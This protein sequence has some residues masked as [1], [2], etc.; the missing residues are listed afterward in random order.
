MKSSPPAPRHAHRLL[1][2]TCGVFLILTIATSVLA[3]D[4]PIGRLIPIGD[5]STEVVAGFVQQALTNAQANHVKILVLPAAIVRDPIAITAADRLAYQI[6]AEKQRAQIEIACRRAVAAPVTCTVSVAPIFARADALEPAVLSQF[7]DDLSAVFILD[8]DPTMAMQVINQTP[9]EAALTRAYQNGAIIAGRGLLSTS[10]LAGYNQNFATA[11][12]LNFG[13]VNVW[14]T[15]TQHGLPFAIKDAILDDHFLQRG[16]LGRLLNAI[17]LP[18]VP[19]IGIGEDVA[20]SLNVYEDMRLQDTLG[21]YPIT[22]LDAETYHAAAAVQ[23][24]GL[25][26]TL[27]LRNVLVHLL[28]PGDFSY[29]LASRAISFAAKA[30]KTPPKIERSFEALSLP[31]GAGPL[32]IAGDLSN[33]LDHNPILARFVELAGGPSATIAIVAAGYPS[34]SA[35]QIATNEYAAA[36]GVATHS[37]AV[38]DVS[39]DVPLPKDTTAILFVAQDQSRL[40]PGLFKPIQTA[41]LSGVPVLADNA[42]AAILGAIYSAHGPTPPDADGAELATQKS[43][44][45]NTTVISPGLSFLK[46]AIEPQILNDN[47]W[48]RLFSLAYRKPDQIAL[49]LTQNTAVEIDANGATV[50]GDNAVVALD[51]RLAKLALGKNKAFVIANGLLDVFADGDVLQPTTADVAIQPAQIATPVLPTI[52]RTPTVTPTPTATPTATPIPTF[53]PTPEPTET[54]P[55]PTATPVVIP[56]T[57]SPVTEFSVPVALLAGAI[58]VVLILVLTRRRPAI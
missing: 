41:W 8:G 31:K 56:A 36:L 28:A 27:S 25:N 51:L 34:G 14:N 17:A 6:D 49:G 30:Q 11:N 9:I 1:R 39:T 58:I 48:G 47:R 7:T 2:V 54:P 20:T 29:D 32:I 13:A 23:Y 3:A 4:Q 42:A 24:R 37:I 44:L 15:A 21:P 5:S 22:I 33:S 12:S 16:Q 35:A 55:A 45:Q 19:H 10:M 18:T 26:Y 53:T 38:T 52:T 50:I 46:V 43:F 40:R 57:S